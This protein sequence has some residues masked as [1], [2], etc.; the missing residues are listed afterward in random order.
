MIK[1]FCR[2]AADTKPFLTSKKARTEVKSNIR[3]LVSSS[4]VV[5][6]ARIFFSSPL[7]YAF[8][9]IDKALFDKY[10]LEYFD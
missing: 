9:D 3:L 7:Q 8:V 10:F 4:S 6:L 2:C 5:L 1:C